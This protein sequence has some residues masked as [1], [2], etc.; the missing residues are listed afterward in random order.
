MF[1]KVK[2]VIF[3]DDETYKKLLQDL[4]DGKYSSV[5]FYEYEFDPE[6]LKNYGLKPKNDINRG[7]KWKFFNELCKEGAVKKYSYKRLKKS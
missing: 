7:Y 3:I 6:K 5:F 4:E 2:A 1:T